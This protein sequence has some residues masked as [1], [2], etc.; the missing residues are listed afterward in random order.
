MFALP[1]G[2]GAVVWEGPLHVPPDADDA[3]IAAPD[4]RLVGPP[5]RRHPPRRSLVGRA[6]H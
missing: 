5:F 3:V 2:R 6:P 1:F 4:R